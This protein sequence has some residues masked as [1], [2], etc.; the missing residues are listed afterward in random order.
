MH[1]GHARGGRGGRGFGR[2]GG[3]QQADLP[4]ADDAP[5]WLIGRLPDD[6]F[7]GEPT[8]AVDRE[9]IVVTGELP[10]PEGATGESSEAAAQG[11]I[12][13]F[14]EETRD[15]RMKIADE[16]EARY[17]RKVAWGASIGD[18]RVLFTHLAVPVMTRLRQDERRVLDTLVDAGVARSRSDALAWCVKLVGEHTDDWLTSLREAMSGV[19]KLRTEGPNL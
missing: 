10:A 5:A 2:P 11:R 3:W 12:G 9:E 13:R 16:A 14:R 19:D 6:W 17:G 8:V 7:T 1:G 4:P 15:A 18:T